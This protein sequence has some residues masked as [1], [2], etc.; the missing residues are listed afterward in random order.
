MHW[1]NILCAGGITKS[2][3]NL[4][5]KLR[6]SFLTLLVY[7]LLKL[8]EHALTGLIE[9]TLTFIPRMY[10]CSLKHSGFLYMMSTF[11]ST[12]KR[13]RV[14]FTLSAMYLTLL[15][16]TSDLVVYSKSKSRH[17]V[18]KVSHAKHLTSSASLALP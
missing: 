1:T 8:I 15:H 3:G 4:L 18:M 11:Y 2:Q 16:Q 7:L 13:M 9:S 10:V 17:E 14:H 6:V 12:E 5:D